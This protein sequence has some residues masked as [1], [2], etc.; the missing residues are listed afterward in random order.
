MG[1]RRDS[2]G[3]FA[4]LCKIICMLWALTVHRGRGIV[5]GF[6]VSLNNSSQVFKL[7]V[8]LSNLFY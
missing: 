4:Y 2:I 5:Y 3:N 1:E 8:S 6:S 7:H